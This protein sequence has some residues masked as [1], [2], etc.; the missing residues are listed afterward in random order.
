M[1]TKNMAEDKIK[2]SIIIPIKNGASYIKRC[3]NS[4]QKQ[5]YSNF[6][7]ICVDDGSNDNSL[8]ICS[9]LGQ[10]DARIKVFKN[11]TGVAGVSGARN[12]GLSK[13]TGDVIG[14]CDI[15]DFVHPQCLQIVTREAEETTAMMIVVGYKRVTDAYLDDHG[16]EISTA[17]SYLVKADTFT[18][19]VV[20]DTKVMGAV[21]NKFFRKEFVNHKFDVT[22]THCEDMYFVLQVLMSK[23]EAQVVVLDTAFYY[24]YEAPASA[25]RDW[26]RLFSQDGEIKY[27]P[28]FEKMLEIQNLPELTKNAL[29]FAII[30]HIGTNVNR[31]KP[32]AAI[33]KKYR[34]Y[35]K[36]YLQPYFLD[37]NG[38]YSKRTK[39]KTAAKLI[40][41]LALMRL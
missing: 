4:W 13:A 10:S 20:A 19:S 2:Y 41:G 29:Y 6:E 26:N 35:L 40:K 30:E 33:R 5:T 12:L 18:H 23:P 16:S 8:R 17:G 22:L 3:L 28:A 39:A 7:L 34:K 14:F 31:V 38:Q 21:W 15:D 9:E 1:G 11:D 32:N 36:Q 24:Y 27:I 25:T 37:N